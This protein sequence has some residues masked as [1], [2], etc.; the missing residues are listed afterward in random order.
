[1]VGQ[2]DFATNAKDTQAAN[3]AHATNHGNAIAILDGVDYFATRIWTTA[4]ITD[5]A[6]M[7]LLVTILDKENTL[8][9]V[10][11]DGKDKIAKLESQMNA[12]ISHVWMV[13][14]VR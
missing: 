5:L 10:N 9:R 12:S 3:M 14:L 13:E 11:Q 4:L 2:E 8:A 7:E 1:M 6:E